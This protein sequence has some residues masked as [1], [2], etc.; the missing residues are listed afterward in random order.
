[1]LDAVARRKAHRLFDRKG[2]D[3]F[4]GLRRPQEDMI[5][6]A[7]FGLVRLMPASPRYHALR[8]VLGEGPLEVADF[9]EGMELTIDLW[10]SLRG[11][12]G[13]RSVEPDVIVSSGNKSIVVEVKW[14]APL[15]ENQL[16]LQVHAA[17]LNG[18]EVG[19]IVML[20]E[21]GVLDQLGGVPCFRRT[22]RD[23]SGD[24]QRWCRWR[25]E[26]AD[27]L[28]WAATLRDFLAQTDMGRIFCG[29]D[30]DLV[31]CGEVTYRFSRLDLSAIELR[32]TEKF[33]YT[34]EVTA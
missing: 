20:G 34:Y 7:V 4:R 18:H 10:K 6:S 22:W 13:R 23:V 8:L 21:P 2:G 31:L 15:S 17:R 19:A 12:R 16:E 14:H 24:C 27:N 28:A 26:S 30:G 32:S 25:R 1:M 5:T 3:L 29:L 11:L 33:H 9:S